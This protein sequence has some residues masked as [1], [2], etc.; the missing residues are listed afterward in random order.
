MVYFLLIVSDCSKP[1]RVPS[2]DVAVCR[3]IINDAAVPFV[4]GTYVYCF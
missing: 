4:V 1:F 2:I 3:S